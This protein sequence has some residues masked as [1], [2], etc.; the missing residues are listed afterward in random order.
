[1]NVILLDPTP[2]NEPIPL[3]LEVTDRLGL[4]A[5]NAVLNPPLEVV[6]AIFA[7]PSPVQLVA[8]S[9]IY[10]ISVKIWSICGL[11]ISSIS[12]ATLTLRT[13]PKPESLISEAVQVWLHLSLAAP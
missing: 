3:P 7:L 13:T 2:T 1:M 10:V 4:P 8:S 6:K 12:W 11:P 9:P 5:P